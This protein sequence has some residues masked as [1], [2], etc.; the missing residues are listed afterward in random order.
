MVLPYFGLIVYTRMRQHWLLVM[1]WVD[2]LTL[3]VV[4]MMVV[5]L[6]FM[7]AS[8]FVRSYGYKVRLHW[9]HLGGILFFIRC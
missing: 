6:M 8:W 4:V 3:P 5:V 1:S 2:V 7:M 9:K